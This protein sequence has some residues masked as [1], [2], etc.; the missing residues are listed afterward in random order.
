MS[1]LSVSC[2]YLDTIN[3]T[4]LDFDFEPTC[5]QTLSSGPHIYMCL[6][7]GKFFRGKGKQTPAYLHCINENHNVFLHLQKGT[8]WCLPDDY[9]IIDPSLND[10][11]QAFKPIYS[12]EEINEIDTQTSLS[13]DL[14]GKKY[15]PGFVGLNNLNKTDCL[16]ATLQALAHVKP[17]RDFF[18]KCGSNGNK[19]FQ[20]TIKVP[21]LS[22]APSQSK[23]RKRNGNDSADNSKQ[24]SNVVAQTKPSFKKKTITVD[25]S[26]FS[27]LSKAFGEMICKM[28]SN[29]RF[30]STVDPHIFVQAVSSASNKRFSIGKQSDAGEFMKWL[31]FQLHLGIGGSSKKSGSSVIHEIF[32]GSVEITTRQKKTMEKDNLDDEDDRYG[33]EDEEEVKAREEEEKKRQ[34]EEAKMVEEITNTTNFLQLTL[35]I[36]E[37]PLFKDETHGGLVIP[38]E[39][40]VNILQKFNGVSFNDVIS[41]SGSTSGQKRRYRLKRLPNN[42]I[43]C[44]SRFK[45]NEFT[46]EKNPTIVPFP[47]KNLDLGPYV[48]G[49]DE[50]AKMLKNLPSEDEIR[51]MSVKQLKELLREHARPDLGSNV[52]EKSELVNVCIDFFKRSLPDLLS[53]KYNL[54]A[55]ITH[56]VNA[57]VGRE[58]QFDPLEEGEY[59]CHVQHKP[60]NQWYEMQDLHVGEIMPQQI[61][62]SESFVL[63]FEKKQS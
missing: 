51:S 30:K 45:R 9:E 17:L 35:D 36:P 20:L 22:S 59:R 6:V 33:S 21:K 57:E 52:V 7:C 3:R 40:L 61:G 58:G 31:L 19:P 37:K 43:L 26:T 47:V 48:H 2:P 56:T 25:P 1:H 14:L 13:R 16:N 39:P 50:A 62:L 63:I 8:F 54:V 41:N 42:L 32:Q 49:D 23:K 11:K 4:V 24:G 18:L 60:T 28:W 34:M 38:Q 53:N 27:P 55:N 29:R 5:S 46:N 44:L 12:K 10:I 15:L